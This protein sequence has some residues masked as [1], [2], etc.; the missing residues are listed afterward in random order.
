MVLLVLYLVVKYAA[1]VAWCLFGLGKL[2]P[3][4][5]DQQSRAF[6]YGFFRLLIGFVF[7]VLVFVA[8]IVLAPGSRTTA[9][10]SFLG[11]LGIYVPVRWIE[12]TIMSI[13]I[14]PGSNPLLHWL[15]GLNRPDRLWRL[16]GVGISFLAD[17]P[18][19]ITIGGFPL[20]RILC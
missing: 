19:L 14:I 9:I 8:L 7:G 11:Y 17:V 18:V 15:S 1:Y 5:E 2:R 3:D 16:G 4:S 13:L 10:S 20:G 6:L 12:W